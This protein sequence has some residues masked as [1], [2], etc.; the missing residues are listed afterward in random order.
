MLVFIII[1]VHLSVS[2]LI[3]AQ[4]RNVSTASFSSFV[5]FRN[6][7][8]RMVQCGTSLA[9]KYFSTVSLAQCTSG[10]VG[11]AG[12]KCFNFIADNAINVKNNRGQ[13]QMFYQSPQVGVKSRCTLF[14][15]SLCF[16]NHSGLHILRI[17]SQVELTISKLCFLAAI[18]K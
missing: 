11:I 6:T 18:T 15:V 12:C 2:S 7:S 4:N 9:N 8:N 3:V 10:C 17:L 1:F 5:I 14:T 16:L 13:C